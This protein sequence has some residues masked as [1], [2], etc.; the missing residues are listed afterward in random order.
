VDIES[1]FLGKKRQDFEFGH[2]HPSIAEVTN[3]WSYTSTPLHAI[4]SDNFLPFHLFKNMQQMI[5]MNGSSVF[6]EVGN[7]F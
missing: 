6:L 7:K 3:E 1:F 2:S 4:V 5:L